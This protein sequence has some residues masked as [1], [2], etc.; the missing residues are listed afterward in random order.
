MNNKSALGIIFRIP[1][2][3]KVKKRLAGEIG[4]EEALKAYKAM[5]YAT[6]ENVMKIEG[7]DIYG[8]YDG[9][10][11]DRLI[12]PDKIMCI[13]Q[14]GGDLG[15]RMLNAIQW[16][17]EKGYTRIGLIGAD[18]PDLPSSFITRAFSELD[19]R[20]LVI[21]PSGDGGYY[22][23]GMKS[24]LK[25]L[26]KYIKW[27][28]PGVFK[29]TISLAD[30]ERIK[31]FVLPEWYD[32][33]SADTLKRWRLLYHPPAHQPEGVWRN[34]NSDKKDTDNLVLSNM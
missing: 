26:F 23:I 18:S 28:S 20:E 6:I 10:N 34:Y 21:G 27:G 9:C 4:D 13:P 31:Y 25:A 14:Y 8:F 12:M 3:G 22:L 7:V 33:D 32:I 24:P 1:E 17:F 15:E 2:Y 30:N 11:I 29:D 19:S 16:L 5:L